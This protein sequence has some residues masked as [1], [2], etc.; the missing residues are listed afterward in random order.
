MKS[1]LTVVVELAAIEDFS[2][3]STNDLLFSKFATVIIMSAGQYIFSCITEMESPLLATNNRTR[4]ISEADT[5][6]TMEYTY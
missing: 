6:K 3:T 5:L 1:L 4:L 2:I